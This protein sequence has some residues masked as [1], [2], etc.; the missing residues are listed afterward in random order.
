MW[1]FVSK[2]VRNRINRLHNENELIAAA[3]E[4]WNNSPQETIN[5]LIV[6]MHRHV[7]LLLNSAE[8]H[9]D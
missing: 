8:G 1:D 2:A 5:C 6:S 7:N 9:T 4:E 3:R